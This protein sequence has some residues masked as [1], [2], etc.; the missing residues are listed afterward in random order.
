MTR[1]TSPLHTTPRTH[2]RGGGS[3]TRTPRPDLTGDLIRAFPELA[4][5]RPDTLDV[6]AELER[7]RDQLERQ[8]EVLQAEKLHT[9]RRL[10]LL[11]A[12]GTANPD[13]AF[14]QLLQAA[15]D[16][17]VS[18][19]ELM[20]RLKRFY[21][22]WDDNWA[23]MNDRSKRHIRMRDQIS[24]WLHVY[25]PDHPKEFILD[26]LVYGYS[27]RGGEVGA[28]DVDPNA[29]RALPSAEALIHEDARRQVQRACVAEA[30][31]VERKL[32]REG[33]VPYLALVVKMLQ[34][35]ARSS[36]A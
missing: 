21:D 19:L 34:H 8:L 33:H 6:R 23:V 24:M 26:D 35:D 13:E 1:R 10:A 11:G 31:R 9:E 20:S 25:S 3:S 29:V 30:E 4:G 27:N 32:A 2:A 18:K 5:P 12:Y 15:S 17:K 16:R 14:V 7:T 22:C 28:P 36:R